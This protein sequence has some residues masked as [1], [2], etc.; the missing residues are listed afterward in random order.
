MKLLKE[1]RDKEIIGKIIPFVGDYKI[2]EAARAIVTRDDDKIAI[3]SVSKYKY[4][5][6][7]GGGLEEGE[8]VKST[9]IREVKE[10]T[11]CSVEILRDIGKT[12]EYKD[13]YGQKSIS[14]CYLT[15]VTS[16]GK[17]LKFTDVEISSGF[18]LIWID[19]DNA[20]NLFEKD[21]PSDYTAKF[22]VSRDLIFL[23]KAK[24]L[25]K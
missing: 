14:Y 7:P 22:I 18:E 12:I 17:E 16:Y 11:G 1:L 19:I 6:L 25:L 24:E 3:L 4:H 20:I 15:K 21:N 8:D 10:E 5:K 9:L 2:R 13:D 23:K